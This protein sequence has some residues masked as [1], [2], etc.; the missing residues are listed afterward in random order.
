MWNSLK[1][2][3]KISPD[4]DPCMNCGHSA[5]SHVAKMEPTEGMEKF[6]YK[7]KRLECRSCECNQF[8]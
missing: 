7:M 6:S 8:K 2:L 5:V 3:L 1:R 4:E